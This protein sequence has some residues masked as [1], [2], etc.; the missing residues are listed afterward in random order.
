[1]SYLKWIGVSTIM[2]IITLKFIKLN[3]LEIID[4]FKTIENNFSKLQ[5]LH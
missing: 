4:F 5:L 3:E 2:F 1:M